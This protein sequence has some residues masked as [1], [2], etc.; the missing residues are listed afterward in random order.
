MNKQQQQ[1]TA[2]GKFHS[3]SLK[4]PKTNHITFTH[5][6]ILPQN[7]PQQQQQQQQRHIS[8]C[9]KW[10]VI[11]IASHQSALIIH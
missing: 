1:Q 5:T 2:R 10:W 6:Q 11:T 9:N 4:R 3:P 8:H 7:H